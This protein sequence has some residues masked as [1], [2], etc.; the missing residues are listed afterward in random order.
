MSHSTDVQK[1]PLYKLVCKYLERTTGK[2]I[3]S[4]IV[5]FASHVQANPVKY[6]MLI[7]LKE[8][9]CKYELFAFIES[10]DPN[11]IER[12]TFYEYVCDMNA[13][14]DVIPELSVEDEMEQMELDL[15]VLSSDRL[16]RIINAKRRC[17]DYKNP[18]NFGCYNVSI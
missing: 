1:S 8:L 15:Y 11:N 6:H 5:L 9:H 10:Y 16:A 13:H 4:L 17:T 14:A 7:E 12:L 18:C 3:C 2:Q